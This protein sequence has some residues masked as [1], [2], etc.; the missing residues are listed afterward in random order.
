VI[1][2]ARRG[3]GGAPYKAKFDRDCIIVYWKGFGP[4]KK[5]CQKL[6]LIEGAEECIRFRF[7]GKEYEL[8]MP[9]FDR[10]AAENFFKAAVI[11]AAGA[12]VQKITIP[13]SV[14]IIL[15]LVAIMQF[16]SLLILSGRVKIAR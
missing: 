15:V 12:T 2:P 14:Y 13:I 5:L 4:F 8:N 16:I 1:R 9:V 3:P 10:D 11:K 7:M 6:I